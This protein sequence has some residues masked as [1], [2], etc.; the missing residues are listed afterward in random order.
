MTAQMLAYPFLFLAIFFQVFVLITLLSKPARLA[1]GRRIGAT[2]PSVAI[3]VPCWNEGTTI[4][5]TVE[6]LLALRYPHAKLEIILVDNASTDETP[7]V[8]ARYASNPQV[9]IIREERRGKHY[10][11]NA[12]IAATSAE[13]IGCLDA[14]SFVEPTSLEESVACFDA[15][16]IAAVTAGMSVH[17]PG[18]LQQHMQN[19]EYIFGIARQNALSVVNGIHV[20][21]GP[22]SLYRRDVVVALGGFK[23]GHQTEDL[24]M[25][26]RLQ[27]AGYRIANAPRARVYT[28]APATVARLVR[29]RTRW[30]TGYMRNILNEYRDMVGSSKYGALG[31]ITLPLG[32]LTIGSGILLFFVALYQLVKYGVTFI[33]TRLG[34]PLAYSLAPHK[35]FDWF[36][37]PGSVYTLLALFTI[38]AAVI[39]VT[40]GKRISKTPG[41]L[42]L[43]LAG[44]ILLYG[45]VAPLWLMNASADVALGKKRGWR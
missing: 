41:S 17:K 24:E 9:R 42:A 29:Q 12:G 22:F 30:T 4:A 25:A 34:I 18:Y 40:I 43:G 28:K 10:A 7:S 35:A 3:I 37:L 6:S 11:V 39:T 1:R 33:E 15:P 8:M 45:L 27:K 26:L 38:L 23:H 44:Y 32:T 36:Y 2:E 19:A 13:I 14:D 20:T 31:L 16:D 21:P 5:A